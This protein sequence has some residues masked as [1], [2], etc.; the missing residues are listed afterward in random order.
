MPEN[1]SPGP[2]VLHQSL[3]YP[4]QRITEGQQCTQTWSPHPSLT[5]SGCTIWPESIHEFSVW[6]PGQRTSFQTATRSCLKCLPRPV[7]SLG[8]WMGIWSLEKKG[9]FSVLKV[10]NS[11]YQVDLLFIKLPRSPLS[12]FCLHTVPQERYASNCLLHCSYF[13]LNCLLVLFYECLW[14][15]ITCKIT[16]RFLLWISHLININWPFVSYNA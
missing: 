11:L 8:L 9:I 3:S 2:G 4:V 14:Y 1:T 12:S 6:E 10:L 7:V 15:F 16:V 5:D 13:C